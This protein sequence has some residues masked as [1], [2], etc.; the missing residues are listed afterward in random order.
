MSLAQGFGNHDPNERCANV[1]VLDRKGPRPIKSDGRSPAPT[2]RNPRN[3]GRP[4][5]LS[6]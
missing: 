1:T 2:R 4:K 5:E 3:A 6:P